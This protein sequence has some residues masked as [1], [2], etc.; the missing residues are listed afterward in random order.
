MKESAPENNSKRKWS[1][2]AIL[3]ALGIGALSLLPGDGKESSNES[4]KSTT[5]MEYMEG[6]SDIESQILYTESHVETIGTDPKKPG[7]TTLGFTVL[8]TPVEIDLP[9]KDADEIAA[10]NK[11]EIAYT[12]DEDGHIVVVRITP[13]GMAKQIIRRMLEVSNPPGYYSKTEGSETPK[14][15]PP[16]YFRII[17]GPDDGKRL[18]IPTEESSPTQE[19]GVNPPGYYQTK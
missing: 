17:G 13:P 9:S 18:D 2:K 3:A 19:D 7:I 8:H 11:V 4:G 15:N 14:E 6:S 12:I 5:E 10:A 1:T 16:G